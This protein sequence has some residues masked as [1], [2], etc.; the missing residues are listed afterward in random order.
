MNVLPAKVAGVREIIVATPPGILRENPAVL[1]AIWLAEADRIFQI[2]G[3]QAIAAL[4]YGTA[5]IPRV[6]KIVGPG[7]LFVATAKR[8]VFGK[9]DI[10]MIAGPSEVLIITDGHGDPR[11]LAADL[12]AQ[13]EHDEQAVPLLVST[14]EPFL[15]EVLQALEQ[16]IQQGPWQAIAR[17]A[18]EING[19]AFLVRDLDEA[20]ELANRIAP[21]HLELAVEGAE[22]ILDKI[23]HAGAIFLG[24]ESAES[25]GDYVAGPNHVLP[26]SGTARFFSP[27][28]VYDFIKRSSIL[29]ISTQGLERLGP[30]AMH[31]ARMEGLHAHA[32]ALD[33]RMK[34]QG[35]NV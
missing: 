22:T 35:R 29:S 25:L 27:L 20:C 16:Q 2:G 3:A 5:T 13:A 31:L 17:Q 8:L 18:I 6:D 34:K 11:H 33:I 14:S 24:S 9:V 10:D 23:R 12:L 26:T 21:E 28:G 7:N 1:A 32:Q 30:K 15:Q 19:K 4:A